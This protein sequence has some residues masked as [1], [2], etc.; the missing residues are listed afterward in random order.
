MI[1]DLQEF[2]TK[3]ME[4]MQN[5][6]AMAEKIIKKNEETTHVLNE[7]KGTLADLSRQGESAV[8]VCTGYARQGHMLTHWNTTNT[9]L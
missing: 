4:E 9:A 2:K 5:W 1:N 3:A 6:T 8:A 7:T